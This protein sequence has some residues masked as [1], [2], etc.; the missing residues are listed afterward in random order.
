VENRLE[1]AEEEIESLEDMAPSRLRVVATFAVILVTAATVFATVMSATASSNAAVAQTNRLFNEAKATAESLSAEQQATTTAQQGDD[2]TEAAWR[3]VLL[4][5]AATEATDPVVAEQLRTEVV[6]IDT[7]HRALAAAE[8]TTKTFSTSFFAYQDKT[9]KIALTDEQT[10]L[11]YASQSSAWTGEEAGDLSTI[12][13]FAV[14]LFLLGLALTLSSRR[15]ASGFVALALVLLLV[16]VGRLALSGA[17]SVPAPS[18]SA[19]AQYVRGVQLDDTLN[20]GNAGYKQFILIENKAKKYFDRAVQL[21]PTYAAA[22]EALGENTMSRNFPANKPSQYLLAA[23]QFRNAVSDG[24]PFPE[25]YNEIGNALTFAKDVRGGMAA[26]QQSRALDPN[27]AHTLAGL[28]ETQVIAGDRKRAN[29]W[30]DKTLHV[31]ASYGPRYQQPFFD[32]LRN[33]RT[34]VATL[35]PNASIVIGFWTKVQNAQVSLNISGSLEPGSVHGATV[36]NIAVSRLRGAAGAHGGTSVSFDYK[37]M[38][39]GDRVSARWYNGFSYEPSASTA[40]SV[41]SVIAPGSSVLAPGSGSAT[42]DST[43]W[44]PFLVPGIPQTLEFFVNGVYVNESTY[45]PPGT[46]LK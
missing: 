7:Q 40:L 12:S 10:A 30:L 34:V 28:A 20:S 6:A 45:I 24:H 15:S 46:P 41:S 25:L 17:S 27:N 14:A 33:D 35:S 23:K 22:W 32:E 5:Q 21:N 29:Y 43:G 19:I 13:M 3:S 42:T 37:G 38:Q 36:T 9:S 4:E 1:G 8:S 11:A 16:G 18:K 26:H 39:D 31:V 44:E 2:T